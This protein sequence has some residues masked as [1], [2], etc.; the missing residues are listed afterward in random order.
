LIWILQSDWLIRLEYNHKYCEYYWQSLLIWTVLWIFKEHKFIQNVRCYIYF[1]TCACVAKSADCYCLQKI[2]MPGKIHLSQYN[3]FKL[4]YLVLLQR[5]YSVTD[6]SKINSCSILVIFLP[7]EA[8]G[9][10]FLW[11]FLN[12]FLKHRF[13][14]FMI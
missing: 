5:L 11:L 12:I 8:N 2:C 1:E 10:S 14:I 4:L 7:T 3:I 13:K 6:Y 9:C